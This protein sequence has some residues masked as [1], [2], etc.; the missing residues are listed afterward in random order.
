MNIKVFSH[1]EALV[2]YLTD[3]FFE[4]ISQDNRVNIGLATG[5]TFIDVYQSII[6]RSIKNHQSFQHLYTFNLDEYV[7]I[8]ENHPQT[9]KSFMKHHLFNGID[10]P[11]NQTHFPPTGSNIDYACYDELIEREEG[12]DV[13]FLGI[14]TNGHIGFNEPGT[15]FDSKTHK[16]T[17]DESTREDNNKFFS[18][19]DEVPK[20]AVT[21]GIHTIMQS[22]RI[23]LVARG[24][25]KAEAVYNMLYGD[26]CEDNPASILREHPNCLVLLD[27]DAAKLVKRSCKDET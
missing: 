9:F 21:M 24:L 6:E 2:I 15:A 25:H 18:S 11:D 12:I 5:S 16:I 27:K 22:K 19:I 20:Y 26:I 8:D 7:D 13:Q 3:L 4:V 23:I 14:G 17:L 10:L 1:D